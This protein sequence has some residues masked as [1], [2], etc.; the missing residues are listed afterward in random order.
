MLKATGEPDVNRNGAGGPA[1]VATLW[2]SADRVVY[3]VGRGDGE[4]VGVAEATRAD[5]KAGSAPQVNLTTPELP[6]PT[7]TRFPVSDVHVVVTTAAGILGN[8]CVKSVIAAA[9]VPI[10]DSTTIAR[11]VLPVKVN[12]IF[13]NLPEC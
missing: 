8:V 4:N 11:M 6:G 12:G 3:P 2:S 10:T 9:A 13:M 1:H 5:V 7:A